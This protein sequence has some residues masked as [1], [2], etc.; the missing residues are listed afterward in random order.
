MQFIKIK[1]ND[2]KFNQNYKYILQNKFNVAFISICIFIIVR[3][4]RK[5]FTIYFLR[6]K[7]FWPKFNS[8]NIFLINVDIL[9]VIKI[10]IDILMK[11]KNLV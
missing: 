3:R 8:D 5:P 11:F 1:I 2:Y 7:Q 9:M 6:Q 4:I 10:I